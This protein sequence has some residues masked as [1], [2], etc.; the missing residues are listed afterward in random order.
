MANSPAFSSI[1]STR[2]QKEIASSWTWYEERQRG[3]GDRFVKEIIDRIRKIEATPER[4][5]LRYKIYRETPVLIFPYLIIYRIN[6]RKHSVRIVA[7]F[8]T[9]LNPKKKFR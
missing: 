1:I 9:L 6:K 8:H 5:P 4:Y 2:A 7:V 3:L